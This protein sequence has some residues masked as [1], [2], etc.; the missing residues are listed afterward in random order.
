MIHTKTAS[1]A[2]CCLVHNKIELY[3]GCVPNDFPIAGS[4]P[5]DVPMENPPP[6]PSLLLSIPNNAMVSTVSSDNNRNGNR[7][8]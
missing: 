5:P 2:S 3:R 7:A 1:S 8:K 6:P 4:L